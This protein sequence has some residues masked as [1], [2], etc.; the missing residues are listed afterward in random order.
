[1]WPI[2]RRAAAL[3]S[4]LADL[5]SFGPLFSAPGMNDIN[6]EIIGEIRELR[7]LTTWLLIVVPIALFAALGIGFWF[8]AHRSTPKLVN[9]P[10]YV[11]AAR[12]RLPAVT[13]SGIPAV[14]D[15]SIAVLPFRDV[16]GDRQ[17][18]N[19][20]DDVQREIL[21]KLAQLADLKV[22]SAGSVMQQKAL[23]TRSRRDVGQQLG[24]A[25]LLQGSVRRAGSRV[26]VSVQLIDA[27]GDE[28]I[29]EERYE[30]ELTDVFALG[31]DIAKEVAEQLGVKP[32][33]T[34]R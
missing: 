19:V 26:S 10:E 9:N 24:V 22:I 32:S 12:T 11:P 6:S 16:S 25:Y 33:L 13:A 2:S 8:G 34:G 14:T 21:S 20:A 3:R 29:W 18:S 30:S 5:I 23:L 1:M 27:A 17:K 4:Y 7:R 15:K 31:S 28:T